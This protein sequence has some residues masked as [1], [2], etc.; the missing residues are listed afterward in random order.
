M[1][2]SPEET[3]KLLEL[4][5]AQNAE[6]IE[7]MRHDLLIHGVNFDFSK[8]EERYK[9]LLKQKEDIEKTLFGDD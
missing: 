2:M 3:I 5:L 8:V 7:V 1:K 9:A 4:R 6:T